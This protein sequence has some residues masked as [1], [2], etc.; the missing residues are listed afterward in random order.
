MRCTLT[1]LIAI[2]EDGEAHE[3]GEKIV[4]ESST[5]YLQISS[6]G[7]DSYIGKVLLRII[8]K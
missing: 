7:S 4:R 3:S 6:L 5:H 1:L 2:D 8:M